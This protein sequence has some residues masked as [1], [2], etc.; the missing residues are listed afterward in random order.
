MAVATHPVCEVSL[1]RA[2]QSDEHSIDVS[3]SSGPSP[4]SVPRNSFCSEF[5]FREYERALASN[6]RRP[7]WILSWI[8]ARVSLS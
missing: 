6:R 8:P 7:A 2:V 5:A 4:I 3:P 1:P